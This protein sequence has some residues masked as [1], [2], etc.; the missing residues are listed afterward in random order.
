MTGTV[1]KTTAEYANAGHR[2]NDPRAGQVVVY[3]STVRA[4]ILNWE[5]KKV[6]E[7]N[8]REA[9]AILFPQDNGVNDLPFGVTFMRETITI[10]EG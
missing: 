6:T 4:D 2:V 5:D 9:Q 10:E 3:V 7:E 1:Y 8:V